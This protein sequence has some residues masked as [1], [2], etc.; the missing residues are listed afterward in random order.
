VSPVLRDTDEVHI[1]I[2]QPSDNL[3]QGVEE[4][5]REVATSLEDQVADLESYP[6]SAGIRAVVDATTQATTELT[7]ALFDLTASKM[8][9][10]T[11]TV[12]KPKSR[13]PVRAEKPKGRLI[14]HLYRDRLDQFRDRGQYSSQNLMA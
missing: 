12:K 9:G 13:Y 2:S 11:E 6:F 5:I 1:E 7:H 10:E 14:T 8:G 3:P 4:A